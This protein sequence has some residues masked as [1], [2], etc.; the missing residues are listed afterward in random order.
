MVTI[1]KVKKSR[2]ISPTSPPLAIVLVSLSVKSTLFL[3]LRTSSIRPSKPIKMLFLFFCLFVFN[4]NLGLPKTQLS[5]FHSR[6]YYPASWVSGH[7]WFLCI[8]TFASSSSPWILCVTSYTINIFTLWL[9]Q[10]ERDSPSWNQRNIMGTK[11]NQPRGLLHKSSLSPTIG[12]SK[13][14]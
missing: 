12:I 8:Q 14:L 10:L 1:N 7:I 9:S 2:I 3:W 6:R 11:I 5:F 13:S 4:L